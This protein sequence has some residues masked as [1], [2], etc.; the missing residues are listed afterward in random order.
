MWLMAQPCPY[1]A[2]SPKRPEKKTEKLLI[3]FDF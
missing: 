1:H 2:L 3:A